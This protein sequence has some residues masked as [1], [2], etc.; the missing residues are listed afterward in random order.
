[1]L[2]TFVAQNID[3][4]ATF[5][6]DAFLKTFANLLRTYNASVD[7]IEAEKSLLIEIPGQF[8]A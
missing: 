4:L 5:S 7:A 8:Q 2:E 6:R 1:M 3:E